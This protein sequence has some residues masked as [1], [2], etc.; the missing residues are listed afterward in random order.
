L[1]KRSTL[2]ASRGGAWS[3]VQVEA[4]KSRAYRRGLGDT[5]FSM[6]YKTPDMRP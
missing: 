2:A 4:I 5:V 3:G 6:T 1:P